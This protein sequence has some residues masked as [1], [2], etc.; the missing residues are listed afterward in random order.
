MFKKYPA[1]LL[2]FSLF[3]GGIWQYLLMYLLLQQLCGDMQF[4]ISKISLGHKR[5]VGLRKLYKFSLSIIFLMFPI[6]LS[7]WS[8]VKITVLSVKI[9]AR[10]RNWA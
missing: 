3:H 6:I 5:D 9:K 10:L 2:A 8:S 4:F 7:P 1:S